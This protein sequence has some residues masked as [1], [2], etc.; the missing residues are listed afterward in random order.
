ML[1]LFQL[2]LAVFAIYGAI[3]YEEEM[4]LLVPLGCLIV[5]FMVNRVDK[6]KSEK[7]TARKTFLHSEMDKVWKKESTTIKDQD[8][9]TIE[10]LLWPK[11]ELLLID[12]VHFVIKDLG[13]KISAGINYHSVDRIVKIPD[14]EKV[15]GVEILM[16]EGMAEKSHPKINRALQFEKEKREKEKTLIIASTHIHLPLSERSNVSHIS[17]GLVDLLVHYNMSFIT[18]H[19]LYELWQKAKGGEVDIFGF[20]QNIYSHRGGVYPL[21]GF[22]DF[23][24][25][26]YD[27]PVQ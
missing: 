23:C 15:F 13:F 20:F 19:H 22:E 3:N 9:F 27:L 6:G 18:A 5:M 4:R 12:A 17:R 11:S 24:S 25:L 1:S 7:K 2:L 8:F 26:S 14:T 10:S 16:S 21:K